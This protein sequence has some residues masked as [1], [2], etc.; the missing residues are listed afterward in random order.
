VMNAHEPTGH[1]FL[2]NERGELIIA[3]L[4][5]KGY[6]ERSRAK[7]IEPTNVDAGRPVV[8]SHPAYANTCVF[9]RNDKELACYS[10]ASEGNARPVGGE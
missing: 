5:P 10:L 4:S 1:Y 2:F 3:D 7:L 8:W 9:V 6:E